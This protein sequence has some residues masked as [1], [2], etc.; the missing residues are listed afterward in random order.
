MCFVV[1]FKSIT[2][3]FRFFFPD[4]PLIDFD[5]PK[6]RFCCLRLG[7][8]QFPAP[9]FLVQCDPGV[10]AFC[11]GKPKFTST[12]Y[13]LPRFLLKLHPLSFGNVVLTFFLRACGFF[14]VTFV[15]SLF[16]S[17]FRWILGTFLA[18][19]PSRVQNTL[20]SFET[21]FSYLSTFLFFHQRSFFCRILRLGTPL[22]CPTL[23][24]FFSAGTQDGRR[25]SD[26]HVFFCRSCS[27]RALPLV[28]VFFALSPCPP[29]T[30]FNHPSERWS[31]LIAWSL[32][33]RP[34][35]FLPFSPPAV[36]FLFFFRAVVFL[37][38]EGL[39]FFWASDL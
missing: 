25:A 31:C 20:Y 8:V 3:G 6:L 24:F 23:S 29:Q 15:L 9:P 38:F 27:V 36:Y 14:G 10:S 30:S 37:G 13:S 5:A 4:G 32:H 19:S 33:D 11:R 1:L 7:F 26:G 28:R 16:L 17:L 2:T 18:P 35:P 21:A 22:H 39:L 12:S 34:L